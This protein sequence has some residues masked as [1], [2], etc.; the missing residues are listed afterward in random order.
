MKTPNRYIQISQGPT[1]AVYMLKAQG[2]CQ[3][4]KV[5]HKELKPVLF[6]RGKLCDR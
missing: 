4:V 6:R 3:S 2:V 1:T 5:E